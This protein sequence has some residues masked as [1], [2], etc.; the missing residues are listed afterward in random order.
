MISP[1]AIAHSLIQAAQAGVSD[2]QISTVVD[3]FLHEY[4]LT[5]LLPAIVR[6]YEQLQQAALASETLTITTAFELS[7]ELQS[8]ISHA[9]ASATQPPIT[10]TVDPQ[11]IGGFIARYQGKE[12]DASLRTQLNQLHTH[13]VS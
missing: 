10:T 3:A 8:Q 6:Q 4:H 12:Y 9:L 11:L 1:R 5:D 2:D 13:L 7:D